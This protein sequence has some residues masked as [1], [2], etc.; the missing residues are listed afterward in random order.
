MLQRPFFTP[1]VIAFWSVTTGWL[2][3]SKILPAWQPGLPP[4]QQALYAS[5]SRMLP[6]AW[7]VAC[8]D[9]P[10]GWA[11][12]RVTRS[13]A[14]RRSSSDGSSPRTARPRSTPGADW[15]STRRAR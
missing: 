12:T 5:D 10:I 11:L 7:S 2:M 8:N 1:I 3:V 9:Q 13:A 15:R 14:G 4:G 6:V